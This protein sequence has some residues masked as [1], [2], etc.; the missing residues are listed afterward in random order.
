MQEQVD[1]LV[2]GGG[3]AG[4]FG[5]INLAELCPEGKIVV[6]EKS[7]ELLGKVKVSG[8]GRCNVTHACFDPKE[9]ISFYPRGSKELLGP[10]HRFMT[11][12]TI[13]WFSER[14]VELKVEDDGRMFPV[15]DDSQTIIDCFLHELNQF[16][17]TVFRQEGVKKISKEGS[18][19][20][21][22]TN[23]RLFSANRILLAP[24]SAP[25]MWELISDMG[26]PVVSPVPSLFTFQINDQRIKDL[27]GISVPSGIVRLP[28]SGHEEQGPVLITHWGLSGPGV[29]KISARAAR[30][31]H[32]CNYHFSALVNWTGLDRQEVEGQLRGFREGSGKKT[33]R[34][35]PGFGMPSR[36]WN[37]LISAGG[38]EEETWANLSKEK[39]QALCDQLCACEF[40]VTGKSTFKDEFV[41]AGGVDLKHVDM[42]TMESKVLPGIHFAGE[43]LNIDALT[44]GFNFQA[45]W[46]TSRLAAEAMAESFGA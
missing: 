19:W 8:G 24:G 23:H 9:L 35:S 29:L 38:I 15:T 30:E 42:K 4:I 14:G 28:A 25:S 34:N 22:E 10:F 13:A 7:K 16:G 33:V 36:L 45:A 3:A 41:T 27:P 20:L 1:F 17:I 44:G 6:L 46:T 31:L 12:D 5:A 39:L 43:F 2:I 11:G 26:Q 37:S 40:K 18:K 32:Q 21:V